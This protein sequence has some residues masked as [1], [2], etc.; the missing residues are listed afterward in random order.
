MGEA[1]VFLLPCKEA[2]QGRVPGGKLIV[3]LG[4]VHLQFVSQGLSTFN[5]DLLFL[6]VF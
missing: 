6:F 3:Y 2:C 1:S 4:L 5:F